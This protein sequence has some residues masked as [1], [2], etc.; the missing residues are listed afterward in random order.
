MEWEN[1]YRES[2]AA[3]A[4]A[5]GTTHASSIR[6]RPHQAHVAMIWPSSNAVQ[7]RENVSLA[8]TGCPTY[9]PVSSARKQDG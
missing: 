2:T 4:A 5:G 7:M 1:V 3:R 9:D 6:T 8:C